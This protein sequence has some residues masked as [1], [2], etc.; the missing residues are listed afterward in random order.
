VRAALRQ[1][2]GGP[3]QGFGS[4]D[5]LAAFPLRMQ[6]EDGALPSGRCEPEG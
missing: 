4:L 3:R 2:D 6:D 1:S 5:Q